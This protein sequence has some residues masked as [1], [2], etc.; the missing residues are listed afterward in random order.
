[1]AEH[2]NSDHCFASSLSNSFLVIE[3]AVLNSAKDDKSFA[4]PVRK[5]FPLQSKTS[6]RE[7][8]PIVPVRTLF[9]VRTH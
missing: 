7:F 4:L 9:P 1:M 3:Q 2:Q 6:T 5:P 8:K